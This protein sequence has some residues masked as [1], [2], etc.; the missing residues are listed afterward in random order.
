LLVLCLDTPS[1]SETIARFAFSR[2]LSAASASQAAVR[3]LAPD[4]HR[5]I[6]YQAIRARVLLALWEE[7]E[8]AIITTITIFAMAPTGIFDRVKKLY[9]KQT[10]E[11]PVSCLRQ[12]MM[13]TY[14]R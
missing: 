11:F 7:I 13:L 12:P 9:T 3:C 14:L 6:T 8:G 4:Y 5:L 1:G 10:G 2:K